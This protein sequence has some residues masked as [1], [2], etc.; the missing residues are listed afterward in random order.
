M[1]N[2]LEDTSPNNPVGKPCQKPYLVCHLN[3]IPFPQAAGN[4]QVHNAISL[5]KEK[6][7]KV[8]LQ[9][10]LKNGILEKVVMDLKNNPEKIIEMEKYSK[11]FSVINSTDKII[12]HIL[13]I[14]A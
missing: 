7:A 11:E 6:A 10:N 1:A 9:N 8:V 4:H 13:E 14:A 5:E 3:L 2:L 12:N